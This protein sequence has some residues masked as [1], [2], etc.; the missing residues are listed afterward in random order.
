MKKLRDKPGPGVQISI[1][2]F[3][4]IADDR[5]RREGDIGDR[6]LD[7]KPQSPSNNKARKPKNPLRQGA[8]N[9]PNLA[10]LTSRSARGS[11]LRVGGN[12]SGGKRMRS[13]EAIGPLERWLLPLGKEAGAP[14]GKAMEEVEE[15]GSLGLQGE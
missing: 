8:S 10:T 7:L 1:K 14:R 13:T 11:P 6:A 4:L 5:K 12:S 2:R 3:L 15:K 9:K